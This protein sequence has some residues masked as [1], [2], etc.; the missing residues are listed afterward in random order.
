M[1]DNYPELV[2]SKMEL[3]SSVNVS[4]QQ[5]NHFVLAVPKQGH[6]IYYGKCCLIG[7]VVHT[8]SSTNPTYIVLRT[9]QILDMRSPMKPLVELPSEILLTGL[10]SLLD[11]VIFVTLD[12]LFINVF[13]ATLGTF[14]SRYN[15]FMDETV[16]QEVNMLIEQLTRWGVE[17]AVKGPGFITESEYSRFFIQEYLRDRLDGIFCMEKT[18]QNKNIKYPPYSK[19]RLPKMTLTGFAR[20]DFDPKT[21]KILFTHPDGTTSVVERPSPYTGFQ[22]Y[23][24]HGKCFEYSDDMH[25]WRK[26]PSRFPKVV[27]KGP[28]LKLEPLRDLLK[29]SDPVEQAKSKSKKILSYIV[30]GTILC[31]TTCYTIFE[32]AQPL[33][34][35]VLN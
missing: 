10:S 22:L 33:L 25:E 20:Y 5:V 6:D 30:W 31:G 13:K 24:Q 3:T 21:G 15:L 26:D 18:L 32:K 17:W 4:Y 14:D 35:L 19:L 28:C 7:D 11:T 34:G 8:F 2:S 9:A 12:T 23:D 1:R 29:Y 27:A 16:F